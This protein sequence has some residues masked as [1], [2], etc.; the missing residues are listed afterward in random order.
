MRHVL[1]LLVGA[2][3]LAIV[4]CA[5]KTRQAEVA[6]RA[7]SAVEVAGFS[8][9]ELRDVQTLS[10]LPPPPPDPTNRFESD[11][12]AAHLGRWLFFDEGMSRSGTVS[13][14]SCHDPE[15][16]WGDGRALAVGEGNVARH[17]MTLWN[18]AY[19][20]WFFWDGRADSLW[21]QA[22]GP[23]EDPAEHGFTRLEVVHRV[24]QVA[25]LRAA[26]EAVFGELTDFGDRDRFPVRGRPI[27]QDPEHPDALAYAGMR[28]ED[29][30]AVDRVFANVG[31][32]LAAFQRT[33]VSRRSRFDV[34]VEGIAQ[35]DPTK[36]G[37]LSAKEQQGLRLFVGKA[38]CVTCHAGPTFSD[39]EFHDTRV[40]T[41]KTGRRRDPGRL[42]GID[43]VQADPFNGLG[44]FS[45]S[46]DGAALDKV[47]YLMK[48]SHNRSEFKTPTLRNVASS[49]PYMHAGQFSSLR[50]VL[51]FYN[52]LEGAAKRHHG[53]ENL[54]TPLGLDP[55][56]LDALE[57]FL[58]S[59]SDES[60]P[61]AVR[62]PPA[63]PKLVV[64]RRG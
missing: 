13:C 23:L 46:P 38:R 58:R 52:T 49:A 56:E 48:T 41:T 35:G 62:T 44:A 1:R 26:Y 63:E 5:P 17:A 42:A 8:A 12:S 47:G 3:L 55:T 16:G 30:R 57:A 39:R 14:A 31:K 61:A 34:F 29:R 18:V 45:D 40:P 6:T 36:L 7:A 11:P 4:S 64:A 28:E 25:S 59:L 10:P 2:S 15:L 32:A 24:V 54:L 50:E 60:L 51:H 20:R 27:P 37:V 22:L 53:A 21:S 9:E 19:N 33:I 43:L